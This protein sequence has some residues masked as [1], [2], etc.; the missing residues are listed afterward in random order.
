VTTG[1][2][3]GVVPVAA[4]VLPP[5]V[6]EAF[7]LEGCSSERE[8]GG[9]INLTFLAKG[10]DGRFRAVVQR[11]HPIFAAEVNIDLEAVTEHVAR[12][13]MVTPRLLRTRDGGRWLEHD[14]G[15]WRALTYVDGVTLHRMPDLAHARAAG[16]L[17][18]R[19]H[20]AVRDLQHTFAFQRL[21]VHDTAGHLKKLAQ[22]TRTSASGAAGP[23]TGS[24]ALTA[25][26]GEL[27]RRILDAGARL[28]PLGDLPRRVMHG[29]LKVSN[30]RFAAPPG[31]TA[32]CLIDLDTLGP[33]NIAYELG[34]GLRSWCNPE[35]EDTSETG[36]DLA[37]F[38]AALEGYAVGA[39]GLLSPAEVDAILPG[40]E[41]VCI[42]LAA[43]FCVDVFDDRYFGWNPERFSSR[44]QHNLV[45]AQ[46]QLALAQAIA[47]C[48]PAARAAVQSAFA[49]AA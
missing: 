33:Q 26:A 40:L 27:A 22:A 42:E 9:L 48:R 12:A 41:T 35:G 23:A 4:E 30:V 8:T 20:L 14:G 2:T 7:G 47:G 1:T 36:F 21:N 49:A 37:V 5:T 45:R 17:V 15:V 39:A 6:L 34:D 31:V 43:R 3:A 46:G 38:A 29:D 10:P 44:R 25:E 18:G 28:P 32:I 11:L 19:F 13:G 24:A 16:E